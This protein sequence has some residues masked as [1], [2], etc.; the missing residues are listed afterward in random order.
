MC[1]NIYA[2]VLPH[3]C[4]WPRRLSRDRATQDTH[5][6]EQRN[7]TWRVQARTV[8]CPRSVVSAVEEWARLPILSV[9][10]HPALFIVRPFARRAHN[11]GRLIHRAMAPATLGVDSGA[12]S[13]EEALAWTTPIDARRFLLFEP[14]ALCS[15]APGLLVLEELPLVEV[16]L[17]ALGRGSCS[18]P[19]ISC[20]P[21]VAPIDGGA[22]LRLRAYVLRTEAALG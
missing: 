18:A 9:A 16:V 7:V 22:C 13:G 17:L 2:N 6:P 12:F 8:E 4:A 19:I 20:I 15:G 14:A 5:V 1:V 11:P 10:A 3:C 21:P